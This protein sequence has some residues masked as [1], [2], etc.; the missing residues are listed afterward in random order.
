M[1][2]LFYKIRTLLFLGRR[3]CVSQYF[4][5]ISNPTYTISYECKDGSNC[6]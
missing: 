3:L 2:K 5:E 1:L 4:D 6:A